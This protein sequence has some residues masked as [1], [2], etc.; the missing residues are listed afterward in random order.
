ME[1]WLKFEEKKL[2]GNSYTPAAAMSSWSS[3]IPLL[4]NSIISIISIN[5]LF[6]LCSNIA[7][8]VQKQTKQTSTYN[9]S[10]TNKE[11][12]CERCKCILASSAAAKNYHN[13]NQI[14]YKT[15]DD[16][17][18]RRC[19]VDNGENQQLNSSSDDD[20]NIVGQ[21]STREVISYDRQRASNK[22][23]EVCHTTNTVSMLRKQFENVGD[24]KLI[25]NLER[26]ISEKFFKRA[27]SPTSSTMNEPFEQM[28]MEEQ[29]EE[30]KQQPTNDYY[31]I[32]K[33]KVYKVMNNGKENVK[34]AE[35]GSADKISKLILSKRSHSNGDIKRLKRSPSH[36]VIAEEPFLVTERTK[37]VDELNEDLDDIEYRKMS[38]AANRGSVRTFDDILQQERFSKC[39]SEYSISDLLNDLPDDDDSE[40]ASFFSKIK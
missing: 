8:N 15:F 7:K 18:Y 14:K 23:L 37:S 19:V 25:R 24:K 31:V 29:S 36:D 9:K 13:K 32:E 28:K 11:T 35:T 34:G 30:E 1:K 40:F 22:I 10:I 20:Q 27:A 26:Q 16:E 3:W 4:I 38:T 12:L 5:F 2:F 33:T 6:K 21:V 17:S 39:Y